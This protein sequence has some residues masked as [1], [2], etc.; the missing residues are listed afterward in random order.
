M[1]AISFIG[2]RSLKDLDQ[3]RFSIVLSDIGHDSG[4]GG[5]VFPWTTNFMKTSAVTKAK[6]FFKAYSSQNKMANE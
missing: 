2:G 5:L 3:Q 6:G 1:P 4:T